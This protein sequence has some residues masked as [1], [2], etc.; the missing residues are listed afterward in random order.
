MTTDQPCIDLEL[1][2]GI[3]T[4]VINN[5]RRRNCFTPEM[6]D[7]LF[8]AAQKIAGDG[9]LRVA[10]L[11]GAGDKAF[12][13]GMDIDSMSVTDA[14]L[15]NFRSGEK[16]MNRA[17][18]AV[19][20]LEIPVIAGLR[21]ACMGGGV[22]VAVAADFRLAADDLKFAVPAITL[23][24]MYPLPPIEQLVRMAGPAAVKK[25]MIEGGTFDAPNALAL[26]FVEE[27]TPAA[28]FDQRLNEMAA[29][30]AGH[31]PIV[32]QSYKKIIDNIADGENATNEP[33]RQAVE[34]SGVLAKMIGQVA[35]ARKAARA[36]R[37]GRE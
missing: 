4:V 11:R 36:N 33:I 37:E 8:E 5:P 24:V 9:T 7:Q 2:G 13:A 6:F 25:L 34:K 18:E 19:A 30:I 1:S 16:R 22:Q 35:K 29:T 10:V 15:D 28:S 26:G 21:G 3:A 31:P 27:V 14:Y 20:A 32:A 23:G 17:T 12:S